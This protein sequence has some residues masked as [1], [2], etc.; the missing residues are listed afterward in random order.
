MGSVLY[1]LTGT[2]QKNTAPK[3]AARR[4]RNAGKSLEAP[5]LSFRGGREGWR[6]PSHETS[7]HFVVKGVLLAYYPL[8]YSST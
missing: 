7:K 4:N 1:F 8:H 2:L 6:E 5:S 3:E